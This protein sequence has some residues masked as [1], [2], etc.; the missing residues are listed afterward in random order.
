[1]TENEMYSLRFPVG[2]FNTPLQIEMEQINHWI[3]IIENF[4]N[5]IQELTNGL[6]TIEKNWCYR[7]NGWS[8]KQVVHHCADSHIN[9][10]IRFKLSLTENAPTIKP[11]LESKWAE[12]IDSQDDDLSFSIQLLSGL[13]HKWVQLLKSFKVEDYKRSYIHPEHGTS[14]YLDEAIGL[15]AWHCEHHLGHI[16][17]A[18][19]AQ[20]KFNI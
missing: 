8:L 7:P 10:M 16:K 6:E 20:G 15:Y 11:Y 1:M 2:E 13:H 18:L 12:L 17:L 14:F 4:P 19:K 3:T 9:S 5:Q